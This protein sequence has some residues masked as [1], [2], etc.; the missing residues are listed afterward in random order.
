MIVSNITHWKSNKLTELQSLNRYR[1]VSLN[2]IALQ[3][4]RGGGGD[5]GRKDC[6]RGGRGAII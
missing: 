4:D 1:S 2:L 5:K 6:E 3:L